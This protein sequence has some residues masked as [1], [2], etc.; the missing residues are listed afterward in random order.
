MQDNHWPDSLPLLRRLGYGGLIP[1]FAL[2]IGPWTIADPAARATC[3]QLLQAYGLAIISFVG[4]LSWG[5]ALIASGIDS[6]VRRRLLIWSVLPALIGFSG[7]LLPVAGSCLVLA[8]T[9]AVALAFDLRHATALALPAQ[10]RQLRLHLSLGA[11][12]A[13]LLGAYAALTLTG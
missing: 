11:I 1:F 3:L 7:F 6:A 13:L 9:A 10:W 2:A 12:A 4:A 5:F 8:A